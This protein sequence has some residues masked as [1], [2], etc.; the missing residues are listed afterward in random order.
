MRLIVPY[1]GNMQPA[2]SRIAQLAEFFGI[3]SESRA[4]SRAVAAGDTGAI[5]AGDCLCIHPDVVQAW[6]AHTGRPVADV[7]AL[8]EGY[9]QLLVYGLRAGAFDCALVQVLSGGR[10]QSIEPVNGGS[11][12]TCFEGCTG[13]LRDLLPDSPLDARIRRTIMCL[14]PQPPSASSSRRSSLTI[15]RSSCS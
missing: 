15:S 4:L 6:C 1:A 11:P 12:Y 5:H 10:L 14:L 7:S 9:S 13:V 3:R 8:V 2:V